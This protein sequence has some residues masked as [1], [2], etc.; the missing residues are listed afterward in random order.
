MLLIGEIFY[1]KSY[2][3]KVEKPTFKIYFKEFV[4]QAYTRNW[5]SH[6]TGT[7][8]VYLTHTRTRT[9]TFQRELQIAT[10]YYLPATYNPHWCRYQIFGILI[11][12]DVLTN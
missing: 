7:V 6:R 1:L 3:V 10:K 2:L 4:Q 8:R 5:C 11:E 9:Q 12:V